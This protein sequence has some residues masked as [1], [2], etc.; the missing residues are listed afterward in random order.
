MLS[1]NELYPL[2]QL[3][4][5]PRLGPVRI[6]KLIRAFGSAQAALEADVEQILALTDLTRSSLEHWGV[7]KGNSQWQ[8]ECELIEHH[9]VNLV[10]YT[11]A[12]YPKRLLEIPDAPLLLY[13]K[14]TWQQRD[15]YS[16]AVVGTRT[17]SIYGREMAEQ[18]GEGLAAAGITVVSGLARGVDTAAH[19]GALRSGRTAAVI[20][21]GLACIYPRE[22]RKLAD[23]IAEK[24]ALIS[25]YPLLT[26]PDK[27]NFPQRNRIVSGITL[28][29]LLIEAPL[30]SGAMITMEKALQH[31][32]RLFAL[33]GRV[34]TD[35]HQGNH[36]LIKSGQA[37]LVEN[38]QDILDCFGDLFSRERT[39]PVKNAPLL[40]DQE[41]EL[42][43]LLPAYE[44]SIEEVMLLS[45]RS[46][47]QT[48][49]LLMGLLLKKMIKEFPGKLY[50]KVY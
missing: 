7:W 1:P 9:K 5:C 12:V 33:P 8:K 4:S 3:S 30:K 25:E 35:S 19:E 10:P 14:G 38:A 6:R 37:V 44:V 13:V 11:S 29:T 42:L 32:R 17:A 23:S 27:Q 48:N 40:T 2:I 34:D 43:Q 24:G 22:N 18:F 28:G 47:V 41:A 16:L 20:G 31:R 49:V 50:R 45:Q 46:S 39:V 21:S 36:R 15:E 26:P